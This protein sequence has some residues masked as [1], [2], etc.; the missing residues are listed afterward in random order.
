MLCLINKLV[1]KTTGKFIQS[2]HDSVS[3]AVLSKNIHISIII[4]HWLMHCMLE[5]NQ[6]SVYL[7]NSGSSHLDLHVFKGLFNIV[8]ILALVLKWSNGWAFKWLL[9]EHLKRVCNYWTPFGLGCLKSVYSVYWKIPEWSI[10]SW[11]AS[12][13]PNVSVYPT[14]FNYQT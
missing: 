11:N 9:Q 6:T 2:A 14:V 1:K 4:N 12:A 7:I 3:T 10:I 13:V 5:T 8:K